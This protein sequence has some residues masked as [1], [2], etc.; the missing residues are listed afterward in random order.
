[1]GDYLCNDLSH[2]RV[3]VSMFVGEF[4]KGVMY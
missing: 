1:M 4:G 2:D 3:Y